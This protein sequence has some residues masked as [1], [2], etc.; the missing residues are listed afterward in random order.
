MDAYL[1]FVEHLSCKVNLIN[2]I[3]KKT[4]SVAT[5]M[6]FSHTFELSTGSIS[7]FRHPFTFNITALNCK[8][9][10]NPKE[11]TCIEVFFP[12]LACPFHEE[13]LK[14]LGLF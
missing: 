13:S 1:I 3:E 10:P 12:M 2:S 5:V 6:V 7:D 11:V 9:F 4:E 14:E 8:L